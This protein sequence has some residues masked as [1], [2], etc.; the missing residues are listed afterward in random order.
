[1]L[2][3]LVHAL[4]GD[5]ILPLWPMG[6]SRGKFLWPDPGV[7]A[8]QVWRGLASRLE[9]VEH[10]TGALFHFTFRF[11]QNELLKRFA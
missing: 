8:W 1:M 10:H 5:D 2:F 3:P 9:L 11:I 4:L 6:P 7:D